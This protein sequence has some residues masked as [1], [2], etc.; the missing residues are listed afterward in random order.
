MWTGIDTM[1]SGGLAFLFRLLMARLLLPSDFGILAMALTTFAIVQVFNDFGMSATVIQ[2]EESRFSSSI[3]DTAFTAS[4]VMSGLLFLINTL[5]IAPVSAWVFRE[6]LVGAVTAVIGLT[7][8]LTPMISISRALLFRQRN[9]RAV[10]IARITSSIGSI[11]AAGIC[12]F[13][14]RNVWTLAVQILAAQIFLATALYVAG[15]WRPRLS[16]NRGIFKEMFGYS[17]LVFANDLFVAAAKNFDV[18]TLGRLLT[19]SQVGLYSLAFYITDVVRTQLMSVLN[20]VMFT[21]YSSIQ[22]DMAAVRFYY[23]RTLSWNTLLIFPVMISIILAGPLLTPFF[24]GE[25]WSGMGAPLQALAVSVMIHAAGGTTS[26]VYKALGRPGLDLVLFAFTS[27]VIL[28]PTL[29]IGAHIAGIAGAAI[30]VA[31]NKGVSAIIRQILLDRMIG[32][33]L[34]RVFK[35]TAGTLL[36][37]APLVLIWLAGMALLPLD[38]VIRAIVSLAGGLLAYGATLLLIR[39]NSALWPAFDSRKP[40]NTGGASA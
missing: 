19:Q 11:A 9:Y 36:A 30:A 31:I 37:Q 23:V 7:F 22:T 24:L 33:T 34:P 4:A 5:V 14:L 40:P 35:S 32:S 2:R 25:A 16:F 21:H 26:T 18:I 20:R 27:V 28:L 12:L 15:R 13:L 8:L 3:V 39:A 10:T 29:I 38:P 1:V 17:G 6:P